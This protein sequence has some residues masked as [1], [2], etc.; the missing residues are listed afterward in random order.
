MAAKFFLDASGGSL[1]FMKEQDYP[2]WANS[3]FEAS[4]HTTM[5]TAPSLPFDPSTQK[6]LDVRNIRRAIIVINC[7]VPA[8]VHTFSVYAGADTG[9]ADEGWYAMDGGTYTGVTGSQFIGVDVFGV[10]YLTIVFSAAPAGGCSVNLAPIPYE[11][12]S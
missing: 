1:A 2:D 5:L 10:D 11:V 3:M 7:T 12:T 8:D 6:I 4:G 9:Q